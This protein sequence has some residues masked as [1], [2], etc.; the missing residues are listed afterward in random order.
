MVAGEMA[1]DF[2]ALP[3]LVEELGVVPKTHFRRLTAPET[4]A[5]KNGSTLLTFEDTC[6]HVHRPT[7]RHTYILILQIK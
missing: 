2:R 3:F 7:F 4:L 1:Q 5:Q 6:S